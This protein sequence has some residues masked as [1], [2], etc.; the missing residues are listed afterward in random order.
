[1][2]IDQSKENTFYPNAA[3]GSRV[4]FLTSHSLPEGPLVLALQGNGTDKGEEGHKARDDEGG[5]GQ[6]GHGA[7][8]GVLGRLRAAAGSAAAA[9]EVLAGRGLV[10]CPLRAGALEARARAGAVIEELQ[11]FWSAFT[12]HQRG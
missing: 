12:C 1:M 3:A 5:A 4:Y 11:S 7:G 10:D 2:I 8:G 6:G 9:G